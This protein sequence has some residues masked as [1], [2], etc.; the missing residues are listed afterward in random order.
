MESFPARRQSLWQWI[1]D[2]QLP[3][4]A[5]D[6]GLSHSFSKTT[7]R[8]PIAPVGSVESRALPAE[9]RLRLDPDWLAGL[10]L[11]ESISC[12]QFTHRIWRERVSRAGL[13]QAGLG[14]V[15]STRRGYSHVCKGRGSPELASEARSVEFHAVFDRRTGRRG[16]WA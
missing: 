1:K 3:T 8:P 12:A 7:T 2:Y 13:R 11:I 15:N 14:G 6:G 16:T 4:A 9:K 10:P 5:S